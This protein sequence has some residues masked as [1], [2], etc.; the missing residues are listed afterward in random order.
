[1]KKRIFSL[2][3]IL[4]LS[5]TWPVPVRSE[6][7]VET[8]ANPIVEIIRQALIA[9]LKAISLKLQKLQ[10]Q[11][12]WLQNTL[13][14]IETEM[15]KLHLEEIAEWSE[16]SKKLYED[17]FQELLEVRN[18]I[19][20][21]KKAKEVAELQKGILEMHE[22]SLNLVMGSDLFT[23]DEKDHIA[24]VYMNILEES[25]NNIDQLEIVITSFKTKM[26][27]ADR[28]IIIDQAHTKIQS[29]Y[30]ALIQ[31]SGSIGYLAQK[32]AAEVDE[33]EGM[34]TLYGY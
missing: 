22:K 1:M 26:S 8:A 7:V 12:I 18:K 30:R 34:K 9:A 15:Q 24:K 14:K 31:F 28:M 32:R 25:V 33:N 27:D 29:N 13:R 2:A 17:Y 23:S 4:L 19:A 21:L 10:T 3:M 20:L 6:V 16:K 11:Q 5:T